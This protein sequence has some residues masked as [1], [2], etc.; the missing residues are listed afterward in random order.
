VINFI[1]KKDY[2]GGTVTLGFDSP[3]HAGGSVHS[4]NGGFGIGDLQ[5]DGVNIFG[6]VDFNHTQA[7]GGTQRPFNTRIPGGLSPTPNPANYFQDGDAGN[8]AAA[9]GCTAPN[10][11]PDPNG[12]TLD[13]YETTSSFVNY[14]PESE[15]ISGLIHGSFKLGEDHVLGLE[16]FT[17]QNTTHSVIAPV[18]YGNLYMNKFRP[19]GS[20]NPFYPGNTATSITPNIPIDPNYTEEGVTDDPTSGVKP[21]FIHVKWRDLDNGSREGIDVNTQLRAMATL[22]GRLGEWDYNTAVALNTNTVRDSLAGYSNG[23]IISQAMLDGVLNPFGPQDAGGQAVIARA[24]VAGLLQTAEG[25][26]QSWDGH[27]SRDLQDWFH[28]GRP[29]AIAFGAEARHERFEQKANTPFAEQVIS[30]TGIDPNTHNA[31]WRNVY[32]GFLELNIPVLKSLDFTVAARYDKYSDFGNTTNPKF[33]FRWQPNKTLLMRGSYSTG[34]RAPSLYELNSEPAFTN[35]D[36]QNDPKYCPGGVS[37][38][39]KPGPKVCNVQ[40]Q[41]LLGGNEALKPEKSK[42]ATLGIVLEPV[43]DLTA[44]ADIWMVKFKNQIG[45]VDSDTIF[46][47]P[48][49]YAPLFHRNNNDLLSTDGSECPGLPVAPGCGYIDQRTVNLGGIDTN[50]IDFAFGYRQNVGSYGKLNFGLQSTW[51]HKYEYQNIEGGAW[52]NEL[53]VFTNGGPIFRWQHNGEI[54]WNLEPFSIGMAGHY[55]TGYLDEDPTRKVSAYATFDLFGTYAMPKGFS[56]TIGLRNIFDRDPPFS[57]QTT[58][59]QAGYDPRFTDPTGRTFYARGT[60][61]F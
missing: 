46:G 34:F 42:N 11:T 4:A 12:S 28:A 53:G 26:V 35:T 16:A 9:G 33:S 60:Y 7:I 22:E 17:S 29:A 18:P 10:L 3:T 30:S 36:T 8:P 56:V 5:K 45:S 15:R 31:G 40:F 2:R 51:I 58:V 38:G 1:T 39:E 32:A 48:V 25:T 20:L 43:Q 44:E 61:S 14:T 57:N 13:C 50:G 27:V 23:D 21:G 37:T 55:K 24:G 52:N 19:D 41:T 49:T 54:N 59:F 6:F 47:D